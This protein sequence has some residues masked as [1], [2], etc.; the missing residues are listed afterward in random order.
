M[1]RRKFVGTLAAV[2]ATTLAWRPPTPDVERGLVL[3][4][5]GQW[6]RVVFSSSR[7]RAVAYLDGVKVRSWWHWPWHQQ[8]A[9]FWAKANQDG[10]AAEFGPTSIA[11]GESEY[12]FP[13]LDT[14]RQGGDP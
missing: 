10:V 6:H 12:Y 13:M 8:S 4:F 3:P 5:D 1:N 2:L 9:W 14:V 7:W 11:V